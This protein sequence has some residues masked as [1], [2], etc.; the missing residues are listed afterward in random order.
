[1]FQ[2][3]PREDFYLG[4]VS[5]FFLRRIAPKVTQKWA[6]WFGVSV[7]SGSARWASCPPATGSWVRMPTRRRWPT[8]SGTGL[9]CATLQTFSHRAASTPGRTRFVLD[10][11][12]GHQF[13]KQ[14]SSP[15]LQLIRFICHNLM[16]WSILCNCLSMTLFYVR[17]FESGSYKWICG[18][19][20]NV[21]FDCNQ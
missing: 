1:M 13:Y 4:N 12:P 20:S 21:I 3:T 17:G 6:T 7:L 14:K 8:P 11:H 19:L 18:K 2:K 15:Q 5:V 10:T 9:S 16:G